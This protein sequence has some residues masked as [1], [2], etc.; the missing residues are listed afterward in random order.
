MDGAKTRTNYGKTLSSY[1][2]A[3]LK[4]KPGV[5]GLPV[6]KT[7][8]VRSTNHGSTNRRDWW[9][10]AASPARLKEHG[11]GLDIKTFSARRNGALVR[12]SG[13]VLTKNA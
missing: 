1:R 6:Q 10:D 11:L 12:A 8:R 4:P 9:W 5:S 3:P 2:T 13:E 7:D